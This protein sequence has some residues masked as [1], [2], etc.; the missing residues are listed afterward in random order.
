MTSDTFLQLI[1]YSKKL[2]KSSLIAMMAHLPYFEY[3]EAGNINLS[4]IKVILNTYK[5]HKT[6]RVSNTSY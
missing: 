2:D 5:N 3:F 4:S 1:N 6:S